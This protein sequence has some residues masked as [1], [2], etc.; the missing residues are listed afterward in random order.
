M[1]V[2]PNKAA[3]DISTKST[4]N[5][6]MQPKCSSWRMTPNAG[7]N[8][9]I[10]Q[11]VLFFMQ[12]L[13]HTCAIVDQPKLLWQ[14]WTQQE[15]YQWIQS[16]L[17]TNIDDAASIDAF[18]AEFAIHCVNGKVLKIIK[19]QKLLGTFKKHFKQQTFGIWV[20]VANAIDSL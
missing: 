5:G 3:V 4:A 1:S 9:S 13:Q 14:S 6:R 17:E 2:P 10:K 16:I 7:E 20:F 8:Q 15:V 19:D 12:A 11:D 18:M